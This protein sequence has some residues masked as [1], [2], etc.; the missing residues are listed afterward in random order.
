MSQYF[1][2]TFI[3]SCGKFQ[4]DILL[5][6]WRD[7]PLPQKVLSALGMGR[8]GRCHP[9]EFA[10]SHIGERR[11]PPAAYKHE[12]TGGVYPSIRCVNITIPC[13]LI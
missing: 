6:M 4:F 5:F 11:L 12:L 1:H 8:G 2:N 13:Q 10:Q 9:H 7:E 3:F